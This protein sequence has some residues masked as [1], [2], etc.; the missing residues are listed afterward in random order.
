M[1]SCS[2][3][4]SVV[5]VSFGKKQ[6]KLM[7]LVREVKGIA[8]FLFERCGRMS[9]NMGACRVVHANSLLITPPGFVYYRDANK[10]N[11]LTEN[12][13]QDISDYS[14]L[15]TAFLGNNVHTLKRR[16]SV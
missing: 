13:Y 14:D 11:A 5:V 7:I 1:V 15:V 2:Y 6:G 8:P 4:I 16:Y 9:L 10:G 12:P 3:H